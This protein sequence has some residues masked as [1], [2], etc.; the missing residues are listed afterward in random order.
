MK[1][2]I[3]KLLKILFDDQASISERDDAAM[4]LGGFSDA[5]SV[6][7]LISKSKDLNEN[8]IVLNSCG[9]SLGEIWAKQNLFNENE[10][11]TLSGTARYGAYSV[12]K[13]QKPEWIE[14]YQLDK[15]KFSD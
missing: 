15:D 10:Y 14:Q 8:E 6:N 3:D 7:A 9:E 1:D 11:R 5:R 13:F 12:I 2:R 4:I